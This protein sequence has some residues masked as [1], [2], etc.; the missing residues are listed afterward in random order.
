MAGARVGS[1]R[2]LRKGPQRQTGAREA[3]TSGLSGAWPAAGCRSGPDPG[4][5]TARSPGRRSWPVTRA[6]RALAPERRALSSGPESRRHRGAGDRPAFSAGCPGNAGAE[7]PL[8]RLFQGPR[9]SEGWREPGRF[10]DPD[11]ALRGG[12]DTGARD[13]GPGREEGC[14]TAEVAGPPGQKAGGGGGRDAGRGQLRPGLGA[15]ASAGAPGAGVAGASRPIPWG[16]RRA[17]PPGGVSGS[18]ALFT[19]GADH[20]GSACLPCGFTRRPFILCQKP[21]KRLD[22]QPHGRHERASSPS[23]CPSLWLP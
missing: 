21:D 10:W 5:A 14:P 6:G 19:D 11:G 3:P 15:R 18:R 13:R 23:V 20:G 7:W 22:R 2:A 4:V 12:G 17:G 1:P 8:G 16:P 9:T